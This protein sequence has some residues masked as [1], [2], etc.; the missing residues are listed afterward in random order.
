MAEKTTGVAAFRVL[1][2]ADIQE[3]LQAARKQ[4]WDTR[5]KL[6]AGT[7]QQTHHV[8]ALRKDIAKMHTVLNERRAKVKA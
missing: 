7:V 4:L 1:N 2:E 8:R 3:K 5:Q 6:R